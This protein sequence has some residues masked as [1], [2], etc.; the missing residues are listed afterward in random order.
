MRLGLAD[1]IG[2]DPQLGG[3][4]RRRVV[5][6]GRP[7][8]RRPG[9]VLELVLDQAAGPA[10]T[11]RRRRPE[12]S[13]S[14]T[15]PAGAGT[16]WSRAGHPSRRWP[17]R[18]GAASGA[19]ACAAR[20]RASR[21]GM[22]SPA[23]RAGTVQARGDRREDFLRDVGEPRAPRSRPAGTSGGP[24]GNTGSRAAPRRPARATAARKREEDVGSSGFK[25]SYSAWAWLARGHRGPKLLSRGEEYYDVA[26]H[27][28]WLEYYNLHR[29]QKCTTA[30]LSEASE[31]GDRHEEE[32]M[33]RTDCPSQET[34]SAFVAGEPPRP[35]A[36][37]PWPS[38]S[39]SAPNASRRSDSSTG[40]PMRS[41]SGVEA[42]S[43]TLAWTWISGR[44]EVAGRRC[45]RRCPAATE[46][47]GEFRIVREI[48]RGG[49]GV[50][51]E[52][53]Q[54]SLNRHVALKFLPEHGNLARF[55]RE[56]QAAGRLHHTHIVP[57]F[58]VGEHQGRH[59]YVMQYIA[60]RGLDAVL[61][62]RAAAAAGRDR[63]V[64]GAS[65]RPRG[66]ADR[67][68]GGRGAGLRPWPGGDP[69]RYQALEPAARRPG[70]GLGHRLRPGQGRRPAEPHRH[71]RLPGHPALHAPRGVRGSVRRP[72]RHLR[73]GPDALRA[74]GPPSGLR[75]DGPRP[76]DPPGRGRGPAA[77]AGA[78]SPEV[79]RDLETVSTRRSSATRVTAT[80]RPRRWRRTCSAFLEDRADP[81]P[82]H[83]RA[84]A[85][86][87]MVS[88]QPMGDGPRRVAGWLPD[89]GDDRLT[90]R[91]GA[92]E[93]AGP[94]GDLRPVGRRPAKGRGRGTRRLTEAGSRQ[95]AEAA[96]RDAKVQRDRAEANFAKARA[97][98]DDY[99][100]RV[101][102]S[103][104]LQVPGMQ[105]LR[106]DL[107]QSALGFYQDFLKE[108][109]DDPT[110]F[111]G[112]AAAHLRVGRIVRELGQ[113]DEARSAFQQARDLYRALVGR[114]PDDR[115]FRGG[116]AE[117]LDESGQPDEAIAIWER[118]VRDG[119]DLARYEQKLADAYDARAIAETQADRSLTWHLKAL[120]LREVLVRR[121]PEDP[122]VQAHL[123]QTLIN[124]GLVLGRQGQRREAL[125]M[126]ERVVQHS[127]SAYER[128]PEVV[129]YGQRLS[130][131][132]NH[133]GSV[134]WEL[135]EREAGLPWLQEANDIA[136]RLAVENPSVP[137]LQGL[138]YRDSRQLSEYFRRAWQGG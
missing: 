40:W 85:V 131:G 28:S 123:G 99:L 133:A 72:R 16:C 10:G 126:F 137:S 136:M 107:L 81:G 71:R 118:L 111:A 60:G 66:G 125:A 70:D 90:D 104:L 110:I 132:L 127:R 83:R 68:P 1:G 48:G 41:S 19:G 100:T 58:G 26:A 64:R 36:E 128:S 119:P 63:A 97:A 62:E 8:E 4:F 11:A 54:G 32:P 14:S 52:A 65:R 31:R 109:G 27:S 53:Y 39:T 25:A 115:E 129:E 61:K 82:P 18:P 101:S 79:P 134:R 122:R 44:R 69:P 55:R 89:P 117:A 22:S 74:A 75:R 7:P 114:S 29:T 91:P 103:R 33:S 73:A 102:E 17:A 15:R 138:H 9:P 113:A 94:A 2:R 51:C 98:V 42:A 96:L 57:V 37:R 86:R 76:A 130:I 50:V 77:A 43:P 6:D 12:L 38:I 34:L 21:P 67:R 5:L 108:R 124:L 87:P 13:E 88:P 105:P 92:D 20:S 24:A 106:R 56:A 30:S 35:R 59:F 45:G 95:Q 112:L 3:D 121:D 49:M 116:L 93:P 46:T 80:R 23:G 120:A 84:G 47:W 135:G 78:R